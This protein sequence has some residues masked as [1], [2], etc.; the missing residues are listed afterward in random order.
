MRGAGRQR[1]VPLNGRIGCGEAGRHKERTRRVWIVAVDHIGGGARGRR[2]ILNIFILGI[3]LLSPNNGRSYVVLFSYLSLILCIVDVVQL[4]WDWAGGSLVAVMGILTSY[5]TWKMLSSSSSTSSASRSM[6]HVSS[7]PSSSSPTVFYTPVSSFPSTEQPIHPL[8]GSLLPGWES[9]FGKSILL[10]KSS[11]S[12]SLS[13][14]IPVA[15]AEANEDAFVDHVVQVEEKSSFA[16]KNPLPLDDMRAIAK[17]ILTD[18]DLQTL[19]QKFFIMIYRPGRKFTVDE[20]TQLVKIRKHF[21]DQFRTSDTLV[22]AIN[23]VYNQLSEDDQQRLHYLI[24]NLT[25]TW[26]SMWA[27][28]KKLMVSMA[29]K[30]LNIFNEFEA[31][32]IINLLETSRMF[33][34]KEAQD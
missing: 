16:S 27:P 33:F 30:Q 4:G 9:V 17:T 29:R 13:I 14:P 10:K 34:A 25:K 31:A 24:T 11:P 22:D 1:N 18:V 23:R 32:L 2:D 28:T 19:G 15:S 7:S 20:Q 6:H 3:N 21:L 8:S 5:L 26:N 12:S